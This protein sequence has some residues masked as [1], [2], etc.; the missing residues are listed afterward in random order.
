MTPKI[1]PTNDTI[2]KQI[3]EIVMINMYRMNPDEGLMKETLAKIIE[4]LSDLHSQLGDTY[5][6]HDF[7]PVE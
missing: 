6:Y 4:E 3:D 1:Y 7:K 2:I 5:N